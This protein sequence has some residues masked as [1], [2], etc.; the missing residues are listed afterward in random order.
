M[1]KH[2]EQDTMSQTHNRDFFH[3]LPQLPRFSFASLVFLVLTIS[4]VFFIE[5]IFH[6]Q[7]NNKEYF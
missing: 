1:K 7:H 2:R 6:A 3:N 5:P 4:W